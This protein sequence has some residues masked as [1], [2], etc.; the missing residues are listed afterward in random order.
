MFKGLRLLEHRREKKRYLHLTALKV[1]GSEKEKS[2][3]HLSAKTICAS[4][5]CYLLY[6]SVLTCASTTGIIAQ[7]RRE[8][9]FGGDFS[10][11]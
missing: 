1:S 11:K 5:S 6:S 9:F 10:G 3:F 8:S 2:V 4:S 7:I